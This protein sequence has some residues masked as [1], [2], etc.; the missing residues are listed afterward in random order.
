MNTAALVDHRVKQFCTPFHMMSTGE[1]I[2]KRIEQFCAPRG[3]KM[4]H[5]G[6][7]AMRV[8]TR[9]ERTLHLPNGSVVKVSVDDSGVATQIEEND[10]LHAIARVKSIRVDLTKLRE[11]Q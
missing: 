9:G 6:G 2:E 5:A 3:E 11:R 7:R 4:I 10:A 1:L 8:R